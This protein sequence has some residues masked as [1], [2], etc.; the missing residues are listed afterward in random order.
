MNNLYVGHVCAHIRGSCGCGADLPLLGRD[1]LPGVCPVC[2]H[3]PLTLDI[4]KD[5][6]ALRT[7]VAVFLR[8]AEKKHLLSLQKEK[9]ELPKQTFSTI[10]TPKPTPNIELS[11][12]SLQS[13]SQE[14]PPLPSPHA[15]ETNFEEPRQDEV[16]GAGKVTQPTEVVEDLSQVLV[17]SCKLPG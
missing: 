14:N 6:T 13:P 7:T 12:V 15:L 17:I 9:K 1:N 3:S 4:C 10:E 2:D 5:N 11:T 8:T 16:N